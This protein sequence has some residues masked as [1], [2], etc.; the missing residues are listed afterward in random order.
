V[1]VCFAAPP[2]AEG[3]RITFLRGRDDQGRT[4][5][6]AGY[7]SSTSTAPWTIPPPAP[8][9][10]EPVITGFSVRPA[11]GAKTLTLEFAVHQARSADFLVKPTFRP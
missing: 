8:G 3:V 9:Q 6:R 4:I 1:N 10:L 7:S 11:P 2:Q 5:D